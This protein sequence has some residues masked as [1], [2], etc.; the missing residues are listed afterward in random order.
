[1]LLS[2]LFSPYTKSALAWQ[3][4][5]ITAIGY[6][7]LAAL[8][9]AL[10]SGSQY[11]SPIFPAAGF[12]LAAVL[13]YGPSALP[14][15]FVGSMLVNVSNGLLLGQGV[16]DALSV[17]SAVA[18]G[19]ALQAQMGSVL[20]HWKLSDRWQRLEDERDAA[21]FL[22]W[23]GMAAGLIS[24]SV[25]NLTLWAAGVVTG[26]GLL[27]SWLTWYVGDTLGI[28]VAAPIALAIWARDSELWQSRLRTML[29]PSAL[30][31]AMALTA[32]WVMGQL[33]AASQQKALDRSSE[34]IAQRVNDRLSARLA[35]HREAL[36]SLRQFAEEQPTA[37]YEA[38]S[39]FAQQILATNPDL[40]AV[41]INDRVLNVDRPAYEANISRQLQQQGFVIQHR[42]EGK[43]QPAPSRPEYVPV[44]MIAPLEGNKP[45]LGFDIFS[46]PIR[47]DAIERAFAS[48]AFAVTAP[49]QLV[50]EDKRRIGLLAL[51]PYFSRQAGSSRPVVAGFAVAV[52]K[53]DEMINL[54]GWN[55]EDSQLIFQLTDPLGT[56]GKQLLFRSNAPMGDFTALPSDQIAWSQTIPVADRQ[57]QLSVYI[58]EGG[59]AASGVPASWWVGIAGFLLA[60]L[61]QLMMLGI[62]GRSAQLKAAHEELS[63]LALYDPLTGLPN[64]TLFFDRLHM[65]LRHTSRE[66]KRHALLFIDLDRFKEINDAFGH[67]AGD[68]VLREAARR[69]QN[70]VREND[71]VARMGGDEFLVLLHDVGEASAALRVAEKLLESLCQ[72]IYWRGEALPMNCSIG[73]AV[74]PDHAI[75]QE[76]LIRAADAA[77]YRAKA[78]GR[79][80]IRVASK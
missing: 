78:E 39:T 4:A 47:R 35:A 48:R 28:W 18:F 49:I 34:E 13:V 5:A 36:T 10:V 11:A 62:T 72:P 58:P 50:Q 77:M 75:D 8:G 3:H 68:Q 59:A 54:K 69:M 55:A 45:A 56:S 19:A 37:S 41:S 23:G 1:M 33:E 67:S 51:M 57:W 43:L 24:A 64:R 32:F 30:L 17:G 74:F 27:E 46:E 20:I 52:I 73:L 66:A 42:I 70:L 71:T 80:Q 14:A 31:I 21:L 25:G 26:S 9:L 6:A 7:L 38:F 15:L 2:A 79:G 44:R 16:V 53:L 12:G 65:D 60:A 22:L 76:G 29:F 40:F 63:R 61:I